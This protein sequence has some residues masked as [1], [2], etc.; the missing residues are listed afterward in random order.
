MIPSPTEE[1]HDIKINRPEVEIVR[2][3]LEAVAALADGKNDIFSELSSM[4]IDA[5]AT[6]Y[7]F[8]ANPTPNL[9]EKLK[10]MGLPPITLPILSGFCDQ[11]LL[12]RQ[13][14][15]RK[16]VAEYIDALDKT[17]P[18]TGMMPPESQQRQTILGG[19]RM[20]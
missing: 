9:N 4:E 3:K 7:L 13:K 18:K 15:G 14:K 2:M 11:F 12:H 10:A 20:V 8:A 1:E 19:R 5:V 16:R 6:A 17:T